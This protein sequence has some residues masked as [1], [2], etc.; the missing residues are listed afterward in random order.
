MTGLRVTVYPGYV[1]EIADP[2]DIAVFTARN[3]LRHSPL[4]SVFGD[5]G[6]NPHINVTGSHLDRF[7]TERLARCVRTDCDTPVAPDGP[8]LCRRC[9]GWLRGE[10]T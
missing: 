4:I 3:P 8:G 5:D 9:I 7:W 6:G 10:T 2:A 1:I